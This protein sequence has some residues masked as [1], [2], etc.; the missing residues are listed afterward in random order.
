M[1]NFK[2]AQIL[3]ETSYWS[4]RVYK[5]IWAFN[6]NALL[7]I[8]SKTKQRKIENRKQKQR[9][10]KRKPSP[11]TWA[12]GPTNW[13]GLAHLALPCLLPPGDRAGSSPPWRASCRSEEHTSE[14]QSRLHL[15]C[16]LLL[17]KKTHTG[18]VVRRLCGLRTSTRS[19]A[20][21]RSH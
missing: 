10:R 15:V 12:S 9:K 1:L 20:Q 16:R 13:S 2:N 5:N 6:K 19:C 21:R 7:F 3:N 18:C 14:L 17:E 11:L 4:P 8:W